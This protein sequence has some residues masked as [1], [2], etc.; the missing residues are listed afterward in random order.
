MLVGNRLRVTV[1]NACWSGR[2]TDRQ[3]SQIEQA[4]IDNIEGAGVG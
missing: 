3:E 2:N 1:K 4:I